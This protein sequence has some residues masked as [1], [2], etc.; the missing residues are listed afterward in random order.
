MVEENEAA[1]KPKNGK[2]NKIQRR[3]SEKGFFT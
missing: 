1:V 3:E 2:Y